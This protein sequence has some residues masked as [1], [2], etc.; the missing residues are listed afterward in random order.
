[1]SSR[2]I[3]KTL[4]L[5]HTARAATVDELASAGIECEPDTISP[6]LRDLGLVELRGDYYAL[7]ERGRKLLDC[8]LVSN[9]WLQEKT[10]GL[11]SKC[12]RCYSLRR[13]WDGFCA[14]VIE[15]AV[16]AAGLTYMRRQ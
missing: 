4:H 3:W 10:C 12:I 9:R 13:A 6:L 14:N 2:S 1:M 15:P 16:E 7:N 11:T 8:C 5:L